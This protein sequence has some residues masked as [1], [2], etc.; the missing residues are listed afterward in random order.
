[1]SSEGEAWEVVKTVGTEEEAT[2]VVGFLQNSGIPAQ[3]E[4]LYV[5]EMP[6]DIGDM[7]EVRVRVPADR[8]EEATALL[9]D[10]AQNPPAAAETE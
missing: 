4:S 10:V 2:F 1:M 7:S 3:M 8:A 9:A 5:S 6:V